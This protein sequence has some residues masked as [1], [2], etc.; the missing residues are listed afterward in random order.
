MGRFI[1]AVQDGD[2][3]G[4]LRSGFTTK[5]WEAE[6]ERLVD[7]DID[8]NLRETGHLI[9][10]K[11]KHIR[12]ELRVT[13]AKD[14][15]ATT[16]IRAFAAVANYNQCA[17]SNRMQE[18]LEKIAKTGREENPGNHVW[19]HE[20]AAVKVRLPVGA[21]YSPDEIVQ[22]MVDGIAIPLKRILE[23]DPDLQGNPEFGKLNWDDVLI[24]FNLGMLY[25]HVEELWDDCLW[26]DF[27]ASHKDEGVKF[28]PDDIQWLASS[29][30]SRLRLD[31]L[32]REFAQHA[33]HFQRRLSHKHPFHALGALN[34]KTLSKEG[35]RQIIRLGSFE[36]E[37]EEE[38]KLLAMRAYASEPYYTELLGEPQ[39]RLKGAT[40]NQ[41]LT[42][43]IIV[44]GASR[45]LRQELDELEVRKPSEPKTWLPN[46]APVLQISALRHAVASACELSFEQSGALVE[47]FVFRGK[48]DQELWAQPLLPASKDGVIPLFSA[49]VSPN[50]RR[51]V[52]VWLRQLDVDLGTR[53]PAF[54]TFIRASICGDISR[55]PLLSSNSCCL[56]RA[57][58]FTPNG[59]RE[60][61]ID[62]VAVVGN[63]VIVG[64]AKCFLDPAEAKQTAMHR[65]KVV[66]AVA[67]VK[68]KASAI[69][70]NKDQ[71]RQ[72]LSQLNFELPEDFSIQPVVIL[73][74]AIHCGTAID[75]VPI[76][77]E[78]ILS[79]FFRGKFVEIGIS[80]GEAFRPIRERVLYTSAAEASRVL[81]QFFLSPPQ[82]QPLIAGLRPR[83]VPVPAV[84]DTDWSGLF[85][86]LDCVPNLDP[87]TADE[88]AAATLPVK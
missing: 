35:R 14:L 56:D 25:S 3:L 37:S 5:G 71:F 45:V 82:M 78:H 75:G 80:E 9:H 65:A 69:N 20:L 42:A 31:S 88:A 24:D 1:K 57:V 72:R 83:W 44:S 66:E 53:G 22:S 67:Q 16:K 79:V 60:E 77:D 19:M 63:V 30:M 81:A 49:I 46:F 11:A 73:N 62:V 47:F 58:K 61:E 87:P 12:S 51:L 23:H 50:L 32:A 41:L 48:A 52:D 7:D 39:A 27:K 2:V 64:E 76:I 36:S 13:F 84:N 38:L 74:S 43:W 29:T 28:A 70:R 85:L 6:H 15:R 59:E 21:G 26:N 4:P 34:V 40:L 33:R 55:S 86:A 18:A 10:D 54:E 17:L 68:R 8:W